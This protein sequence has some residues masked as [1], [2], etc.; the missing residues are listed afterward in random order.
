M[1]KITLL[2]AN[3]AALHNIFNAPLRCSSSL[4]FAINNDKITGIA[5]GNELFKKWSYDIALF[6][7]EY[8]PI[9]TSILCFLFDGNMFRNTF[10]HFN[11]TINIEIYYDVNDKQEGIAT[12]FRLFDDDISIKVNASI[13]SLGYIAETTARYKHFAHGDNAYTFDLAA[14]QLDK[15]IALS[16]LNTTDET[17]VQVL[18][19]MQNGN[20]VASNPAFTYIIERNAKQI[21]NL[22]IPRDLLGFL[23]RDDY[24]VTISTTPNGIKK[25]VF[26][27][28]N[29]DVIDVMPATKDESDFDDIANEFEDFAKSM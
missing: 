23:L 5:K 24:V 19:S 9:S 1:N 10:K 28:K 20:L 15:I 25:L 27:S 17:S 14:H 18:L 29:Q 21:T 12:A 2:N 22:G 16:A 7:P 11:G 4:S 8:A 26:D 13:H 6:A 3:K